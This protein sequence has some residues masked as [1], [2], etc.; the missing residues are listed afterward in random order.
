MRR[1]SAPA[2]R[3]ATAD[4]QYDRLLRCRLARGGAEARR[5]VDALGIEEDAAAAF[6]IGP[7]VEMVF[8]P[9][10]HRIA[11]GDDG[12]EAQVMCVCCGDPFFGQPARD[13]KGVV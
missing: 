11:D 9:E 7:I 2:P 13:R 3:R 12:A 4:L 6:I 8:H 5:I 10:M 1:S